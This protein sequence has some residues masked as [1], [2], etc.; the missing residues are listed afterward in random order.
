MEIDRVDLNYER[1]S[2][3][4]SFLGPSENSILKSAYLLIQKVQTMSRQQR[5]EQNTFQ[6]KLE[7]QAATFQKEIARHKDLTRQAE[8]KFEKSKTAEKSDQV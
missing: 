1:N 8:V 3:S 4:Q 5:S 7:E 6:I 2:D